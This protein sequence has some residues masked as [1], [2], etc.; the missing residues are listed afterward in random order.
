[1]KKR[2]FSISSKDHD[3]GLKGWFGGREG[4]GAM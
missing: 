2:R 3:S 4:G 1:M